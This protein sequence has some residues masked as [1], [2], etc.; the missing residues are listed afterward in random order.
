[1]TSFDIEFRRFERHPK[2]DQLSIIFTPSIELIFETLETADIDMNPYHSMIETIFN[3]NLGNE[4]H[5][6]NGTNQ[7]KKTTKTPVSNNNKAPQENSISKE[8]LA[9]NINTE[10]LANSIKPDNYKD[11]EYLQSHTWKKMVL[12]VESTTKVWE[13]C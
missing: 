7:H 4:F 6:Q 9:D 3:R 11:I 13:N 1:M 8:T 12:D 10:I 2:G 5:H